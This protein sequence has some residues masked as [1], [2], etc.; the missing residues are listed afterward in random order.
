MAGLLRGPTG[1]LL[2]G[3]GGALTRDPDC[4]CDPTGPCAEFD[5]Y[6]DSIGS[7]KKWE[8]GSTGFIGTRPDFDWTG[9]AWVAV[10]TI[11][12]SSCS[13][14]I[15]IGCTGAADGF[16]NIRV[17]GF[18]GDGAS[19]NEWELEDASQSDILSGATI[20]LPWIGFDTDF[21]GACN[22]YNEATSIDV[23]L[24]DA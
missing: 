18:L 2:R 16:A 6:L 22:I 17:V 24:V 4:C 1:K 12:E 20:T 7:T 5:S 23:R 21:S 11:G 9:S 19:F 15:E 8:W 10:F 13:Y 14:R 3:P